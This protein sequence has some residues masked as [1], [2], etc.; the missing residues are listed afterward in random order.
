MPNMQTRP[1]ESTNFSF[2]VWK[3]FVFPSPSGAFSKKTRGSSRARATRSFS[4]NTRAHSGPN[5]SASVSPT[6]SSGLRLFANAA[7][8]RLQARYTPVWASFEKLMPGMLLNS[9]LTDCC[10]SA[11]VSA[12]RAAFSAVTIVPVIMLLFSVFLLRVM[13]KHP[14]TPCQNTY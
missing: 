4:T 9:A 12:V 14:P 2:V 8:A 1:V 6:T 11:M 7:K 13:P 3:C 10:S 5:S